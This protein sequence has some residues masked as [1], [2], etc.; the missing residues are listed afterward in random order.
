MVFK[1]R[2]REGSTFLFPYSFKTHKS[3]KAHATEPILE[4]LQEEQFRSTSTST[5]D[6]A[7]LDIAAS[8]FFLGGGRFERTFF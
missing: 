4:P 5:V 6:G 3:L 7:R 1:H 2:L 8:G